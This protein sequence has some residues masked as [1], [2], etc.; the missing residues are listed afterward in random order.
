MNSQNFK[1]LLHEMEPEKMAQYSVRNH[2]V[3]GLDYLCLHRSEKLTVKLYFIDPDL[4][5]VAKEQFLVTPHTHRYAFE[6]TVLRGNLMHVR[7]TE[8]PGDEY[9]RALYA[10]ETRTRAARGT[11]DLKPQYES[12]KPGHTYWC[13]TSDIHTLL[14]P[15]EIVLLGLVQ[16]ADTCADSTV[17]VRKGRDMAF[18]LSRPMVPVEAELLRGY[19]LGLIR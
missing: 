5:P 8:R 19:A 11:V 6:S 4:L 13:S 18:P 14:V 15:E 12:H 10:P 2:H 3:N 17:Y 1:T 16:F 9:D 7:F